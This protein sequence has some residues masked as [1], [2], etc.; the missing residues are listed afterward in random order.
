LAAANCAKPGNQT[1]TQ[2]QAGAA[3]TPADAEE[4][5]TA[6]TSKPGANSW[7]A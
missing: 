4:W 2:I 3:P 1:L 7:P 6:D 5:K